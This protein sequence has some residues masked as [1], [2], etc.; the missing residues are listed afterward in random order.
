MTPMNYSSDDFF[1][2]TD[3]EKKSEKEAEKSF[4]TLEKHSHQGS[5]VF[6][7]RAIT[8]TSHVEIEDEGQGDI[9]APIELSGSETIQLADEGA[10]G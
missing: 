5:P 7:K 6:V 1:Q 3:P 2:S 8:M 4:S 10:E 9:T